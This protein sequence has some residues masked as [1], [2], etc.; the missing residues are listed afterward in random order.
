MRTSRIAL[1]L[2]P[3]IP[4]SLSGLKKDFQHEHS[5]GM[6]KDRYVQFIALGSAVGFL[7]GVDEAMRNVELR[8]KYPLLGMLIGGLGAAAPPL[9]VSFVLFY[10]MSE[11]SFMDKLY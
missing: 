10:M 11:D 5:S 2:K 8:L 1:S 3:E 9:G 6:F 7:L 4:K